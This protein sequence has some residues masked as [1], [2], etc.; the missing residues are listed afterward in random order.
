[1]TDREDDKWARR[2]AT[3]RAEPPPSEQ[4]PSESSPSEQLVIPRPVNLTRAFVL[5][6]V[7]GVVTIPAVVGIVVLIA[8]FNLRVGYRGARIVLTVVFAFSFVTPLAIVGGLASDGFEP[9][10]LLPLTFSALVAAAVVLMWQPDVSAYLRAAR[11][12]VP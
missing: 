3:R 5:W 11:G 8:A 7:A 10:M 12:A 6:V 4:P 9:L 2:R 1:V